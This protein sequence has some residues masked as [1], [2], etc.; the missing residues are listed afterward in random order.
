[1]SNGTVT[2][3]TPFESG[4]VTSGFNL[5]LLLARA[6]RETL[7]RSD[8]ATR[9]E[10]Q[11]YNWMAAIELLGKTAAQQVHKFSKLSEISHLWESFLAIP[12]VRELPKHS[13]EILAAARERSMKLA[14]SG[15]N[16]ISDVDAANKA[17]YLRVETLLSAKGIK[18]KLPVAP[19]PIQVV[20]DSAG[21]EYCASASRLTGGIRWAYQPTVE[22]FLCG[23]LILEHI[24]A[25][26]YL[27]HLVP[28]NSRMD[29]SFAERWLVFAQTS[30]IVQ[31]GTEPLWKRYLWILYRRKLM[32]HIDEEEQK[33]NLDTLVSSSFGGFLAEETAKAIFYISPASFWKL[34]GEMMGGGDDEKLA[35]AASRIMEDFEPSSTTLDPAKVYTINS[36]LALMG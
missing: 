26:E 21:R 16:A 8:T 27:S 31:V 17:A 6:L 28:T 7:E 4:A 1:M 30:G 2:L 11:K 14:T 25:H 23:L 32:R 9:V 20:F 5:M 15:A 33:Q 34:T 10:D 13:G 19:V 29:V 24:F 18:Q 12:E 22:H 3:G 35:L 36:L